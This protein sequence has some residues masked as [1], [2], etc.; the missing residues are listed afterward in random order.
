MLV[1]IFGEFHLEVLNSLMN[2]FV[3]MEYLDVYFSLI[4]TVFIFFV[5]LFEEV[6]IWE[7]IKCKC[8]IIIKNICIVGMIML[9]LMSVGS[10]SELMGGF[11]Y[12]NF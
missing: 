7:K 12:A 6:G 9:I 4:G 10:V 1:N 2:L 11:M 3:G 8:P 5:D